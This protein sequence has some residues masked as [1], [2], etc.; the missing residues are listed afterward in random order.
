MGQKEQYGW[1]KKFAE[2]IFYFHPKTK[3]KGAG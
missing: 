1:I 2:G 3:N